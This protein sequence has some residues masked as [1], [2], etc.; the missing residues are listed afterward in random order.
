MVI[1]YK[2]FWTTNAQKELSAILEYL[3]IKW[4]SKEIKAFIERL[5]NVLFL[6]SQNPEMFQVSSVKVNIRKAIISKH[7][8][9][10][11]RVK[12]KQIEILSLFANKQSPEKLK[13]R[14]K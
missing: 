3:T 9:I 10:Y 12:N 2:I 8:T 5:E 6:M 1:G 7:N 13:K 4:T 14:L 11:F